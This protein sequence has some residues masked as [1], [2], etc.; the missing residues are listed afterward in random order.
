MQEVADMASIGVVEGLISGIL[1]PQVDEEKMKQKFC[2]IFHTILEGLAALPTSTGFHLSV[3]VMLAQS[4]RLKQSLE[5]VRV[6]PVGCSPSKDMVLSDNDLKNKL[7]SSD[8]RC[9]MFFISAA[10]VQG[11]SQSSCQSQGS[12][13][14][15]HKLSW[16]TKSIS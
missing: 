8:C 15:H 10:N 13:F 9:P 2:N 4:M 7:V 14:S 11:H 1:E 12:P 5:L 3:P 6:E 16:I